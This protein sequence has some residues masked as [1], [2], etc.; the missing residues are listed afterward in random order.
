MRDFFAFRKMI[1]AHVI[2]V[3][4]VLGLIGIVIVAIAAVANDQPLGGLL[5]LVFG[6]LYW[7]IICEVFIVLFRMNNTLT[8]IQANTAAMTGRGTTSPPSPAA[9]EPAPV[10]GDAVEP[11]ATTSS[12]DAAAGWYDD[13]DRPGRKRWWD[14][15]TWGVRDVEHSGGG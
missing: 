5:L 8:A 11:T 4:F 6:G 1:S 3:V 10:A 15:T 9:V 13:P 7:R 12:D 14:G 2:Q